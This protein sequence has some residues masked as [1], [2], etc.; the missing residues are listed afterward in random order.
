MYETT[1]QVE[2]PK[3][4]S[5]GVD[6]PIGQSW[7]Q[8]D[9]HYLAQMPTINESSSYQAKF[10]APTINDSSS[11]QAKISAPA[12]AQMRTT[13]VDACEQPRMDSG[14][15]TAEQEFRP[16][17]V[18]DTIT[19]ITETSYYEAPMPTVIE[20][21]AY[22]QVQHQRPG[23]EQ[24][25]T[26]AVEAYQPARADTWMQTSDS[27][28][29]D[30]AP[31]K[32]SRTVRDNQSFYSKQQFS[33]SVSATPRSSPK[34]S[35]RTSLL[36]HQP[37]QINNWGGQTAPHML[38]AV[39]QTTG[40]E[41]IIIDSTLPALPRDPATRPKTQDS[42]TVDM[43]EEF[44]RFE[45]KNYTSVTKLSHS[46]LIPYQAQSTDRSQYTQRGRSLESIMAKKQH[47]ER[48]L[49][50]QTKHHSEED[51]FQHLLA[52]WGPQGLREQ[53]YRRCGNSLE[54]GM[55]SSSTRR[56][57]QTEKLATY[58]GISNI[59][60]MPVGIDDLS[61]EV[62]TDI[63][64]QDL[65][66]MKRRPHK[67]KRIQRGQSYVQWPPVDEPETQAYRSLTG[68]FA[69]VMTHEM[70]QET[71]SNTLH[72][73]PVTVHRASRFPHMSKT[74]QTSMHQFS[75]VDGGSGCVDPVTGCDC[76][77]AYLSDL[78][79][80]SAQ[81]KLDVDDY[82][83]GLQLVNFVKDQ[84][85]VKRQLLVDTHGTLTEV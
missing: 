84:Q 32:P 67:N 13:G 55:V 20:A 47:M 26:V 4:K 85:E 69:S 36:L 3:L 82:Y 42:S 75:V 76:L 44:L 40:V 50:Q 74:T 29:G 59:Y 14:M 27:I 7:L 72:V 77:P 9:S 49:R 63:E 30:M 11:Y 70:T 58:S 52:V 10:S 2:S 15:Q 38:P 56:V 1:T 46:H 61:V 43:Q 5:T 48:G 19:Q 64:F 62:Q 57:R 24:I 37:K 18:K 83:D 25:S 79:L 81:V 73:D 51:C 80:E 31:S 78:A 23:L 16:Q 8:S 54:R 12:P 60:D 34:T 39:T 17:T 21:S 45:R 71:Y 33:V 6:A 66:K 35:P 53:I 68:G 65:Q 41:H 28:L 22:R